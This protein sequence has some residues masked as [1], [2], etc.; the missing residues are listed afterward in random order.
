MPGAWWSDS[1][2]L[3]YRSLFLRGRATST[4]APIFLLD[5]ATY[6]FPKP[7]QLGAA[8]WRYT[9]D[10]HELVVGRKR[11]PDDDLFLLRHRLHSTSATSSASVNHFRSSVHV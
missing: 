4:F 3:G 8:L 1:S 7:L 11:R 2:P 5:I 9:E 6:F 10:L